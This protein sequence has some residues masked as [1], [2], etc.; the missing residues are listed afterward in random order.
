MFTIGDRVVTP[1]NDEEGMVLSVDP[2][3]EDFERVEV[4]TNLGVLYFADNALAK[5][6]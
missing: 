4:R 6:R 5:I 3:R 2:D 1:L